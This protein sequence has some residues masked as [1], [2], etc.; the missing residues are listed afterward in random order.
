MCVW[1]AL[2]GYVACVY[3][4]TGMV[5]A[6][7]NGFCI[8]N[9]VPT[10]DYEGWDEAYLGFCPWSGEAEGPVWAHLS[11]LGSQVMHGTA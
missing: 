5:N 4:W 3:L 1:S 8:C 7:T 11:P 9:K 10:A 6:A 2:N